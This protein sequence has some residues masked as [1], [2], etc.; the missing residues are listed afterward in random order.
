MGAYRSEKITIATTPIGFTSTIVKDGHINKAYEAFF[1]VE[2]A[3][4]RYTTDGTDPSTTVGLL[5]EI[6][7]TINISGESDVN[8]FKAIRTGATSAVIQPHYF[9]GTE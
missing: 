9:D 2:D 7:D 3:Q 6:G 8:R 5:A 4:F 1:V